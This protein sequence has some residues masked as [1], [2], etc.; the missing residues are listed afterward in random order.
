MMGVFVTKGGIYDSSNDT[1]ETEYPRNLD[2]N[3]ELLSREEEKTEEK[4]RDKIP[5]GP[6]YDLKE[7]QRQ[8]Q[9]EKEKDDDEDEPIGVVS[10][11]INFF[12]SI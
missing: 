8:L 3:I 11:S 1:I 10:A 5:F 7:V 2:D 12:I 4:F 6:Q 9:K